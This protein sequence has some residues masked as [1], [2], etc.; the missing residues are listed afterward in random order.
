MTRDKDGLI[1]HGLL[2]MAVTQVANVCNFLFQLVMGRS[3]SQEEYG[4]LTPLLG[5]VL[6]ITTPMLAL[7]TVVSH[8]TARLVQEDRVGDVQRLLKRW[9]LI[10]CVIGLGIIALSVGGVRW[11]MAYL[12]C[13]DPNLIY[14]TGILL[15]VMLFIPLYTGVLNGFQEFVGYAAV[16][17]LMSVVRF[18]I[19]AGLIWLVAINAGVGLTAQLAG[20]VCSVVVGVW[21]LNRKLRIETPT[22]LPLPKMDTYF[23]HALLIIGGFSILFS[24]DP[25]LIKHYFPDQAGV[26]NRAG[27]IARS[28]V[29]L[30]MPIA[31]ALFPKVVSYRAATAVHWRTLFK[32][33]LFTLLILVG[34]AGVCAWV[35]QIPLLILYRDGQPTE[36]M[37]NLVRYMGLA[38]VPLGIVFQ[39]IHFELAQHRFR[40]GYVVLLCAFGYL[41]YIQQHHH[42]VFYVIKGLAI[43]NSAAL[44]GLVAVM[45][46]EN[47]LFLRQNKNDR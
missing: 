12:H 11:F 18:I 29:F 38:F 44:A 30:P 31:S 16:S 21:L 39:L 2:L 6:I 32:A 24:A 5:A 28:L 19:A 3:L 35:P 13:S 47:R 40:S 27:V 15:A 36:E 42:D 1:R 33:I 10:L 26:Y 8:F 9:V 22:D 37:I 25:I 45:F 20:A 14:I 23:F 17:H 41:M 34:A 46:I 4:L 43:F 7:R